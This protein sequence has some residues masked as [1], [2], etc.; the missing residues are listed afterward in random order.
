MTK[1]QTTAQSRKTSGEGRTGPLPGLATHIPA[2]GP[3]GAFTGS[4]EGVAWRREHVF[5]EPSFPFAI[6]DIPR[7]PELGL[8]THQGFSE[9]V[10]IYAGRAMHVTTEERY[11]IGPG[12]VFVISGESAHGYADVDDLYL[13]NVVFEDARFLRGISEIKRLPGFH[14]LF[15]LEPRYR[16]QH[17]F[18]S[19]LRLAPDELDHLL[20]LLERMSRLYT[21]RDPG[22]ELRTRVAFL[23]LVCYLC[24]RYV[25]AKNPASRSL[26][27]MDNVIQYLESNYAEPVSLAT[28][29]EQAHMSERNLLLLFRDATGLSPIEYLIRVRIAHAS[30]LLRAT[31]RSVTEV[32]HAAGFLDSNYF[33][34]QFKRF[35]GMRPSEYRERFTLRPVLE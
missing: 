23:E 34:R 26:L 29:A 6:L 27:L 1:S 7:H 31:N 8:H 20:T 4:G 17:W 35:T 14:A 10:V 13:A 19:R 18:E 2:G 11:P 3:A 22:Y 32:A 30:E 25:G 33:S 5:P 15:R 21:A 12:D 16:R 24:D 28:L 9:L